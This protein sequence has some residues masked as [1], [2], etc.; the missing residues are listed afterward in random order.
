MRGEITPRNL[1]TLLIQMNMCIVTA[2]KGNP[3]IIQ[4]TDVAFEHTLSINP[5]FYHVPVLDLLKLHSV[6]IFEKDSCK[7]KNKNAMLL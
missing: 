3:T 6:A 1:H 5:D 4:I 2:C 7:T